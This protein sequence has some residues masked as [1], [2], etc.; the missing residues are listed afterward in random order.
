MAKTDIFKPLTYHGTTYPSKEGYIADG[1]GVV[2]KRTYFRGSD[3][4]YYAIDNNGNAVPM[5]LNNPNGGDAITLQYADSY[6]G[7]GPVVT[8]SEETW[9]YLRYRN[10]ELQGDRNFSHFD[11]DENGK[12]I[13]LRSNV[14]NHDLNARRQALMRA[15]GY[16]VPD[17]G[18]WD[19]KQ[20]AI[21]DKLTIKDK[22]YDTTLTGFGKAMMDKLT[23]NTT[24]RDNPLIQDAVQAYNPDNVDWDKTNRSHNKFINAVDGTWGPIA[25]AAFG[26]PILKTAVSAPLTTAT[27]LGGGA[28]GGW[29]VDKAS[30]ALT[31]RSIGD[32]V[33]KYTSLSSDMGEMFN[34][35]YYAGGAYGHFVSNNLASRGRYTL[36]YLSPA[37]YKGHWL[38]FP[39]TISKPFYRKPPTFY[40]NR[41]PSWYAKYAQKEGIDAAE[42][43]FQNGLVWAGIPEEEAAHPMYIKNADGSYRLSQDGFSHGL[44]RPSGAAL[45]PDKTKIDQDWFTVSGI[46]GEHSNFKKLGDWMGAKLMQ[47]E[48]EQKLNPQ[49]L[50]TDPVKR[51]IGKYFS[52]NNKAYKFLDQLGGKSASGVMGYKPFTI[53]QNYIHT[54]NK[55]YPIYEDPANASN[56]PNFII[57]R[58]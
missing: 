32:N 18:L 56:I 15:A 29:A 14:E 50:L 11:I 3:G 22:D 58:D 33:A 9:N 34:P 54:G 17:N 7:D 20:Q 35:G 53:K 4:Q 31:G 52:E 1:N 45:V 5:H 13:N 40:N 47:F 37:S 25:M 23:G 6:Q 51:G 49:W 42:Q 19:E 44:G 48:D 55:V 12:R 27:T 10:Q 41:K 24:Y 8:P 36:N 46:G 30:K 16:D 21:W 26:S 2:Q 43:R 38:D 39:L 57:R 28:L